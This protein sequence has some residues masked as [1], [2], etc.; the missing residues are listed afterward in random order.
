MEKYSTHWG[1]K[2]QGVI[3]LFPPVK[4][5]ANRVRPE[6]DLVVVPE[7]V[8]GGG[9]IR[10]SGSDEGKR[11]IKNTKGGSTSMLGR[12]KRGDIDS[13]KKERGG[14]QIAEGDAGNE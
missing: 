1:T 2:V 12:T 6:G 14:L 7:G 8:Q 10:L 9:G 11:E 3:I 5:T 4:E 13:Q